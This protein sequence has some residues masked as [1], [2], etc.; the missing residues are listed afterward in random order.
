[1]LWIIS[2]NHTDPPPE[3]PSGAAALSS[4]G[5]GAESHQLKHF[6]LLQSPATNSGTPTLFVKQDN[7]FMTKRGQIQT[8]GRDQFLAGEYRSNDPLPSL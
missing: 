7:Y 1:M 6:I 3:H 4:P 8:G 2:L 5:F